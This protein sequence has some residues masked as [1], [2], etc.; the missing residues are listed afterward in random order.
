MNN[1]CWKNKCMSKLM[2]KFPL[3]LEKR[4]QEKNFK[5]RENF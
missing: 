2:S 5:T 4:K 1:I 3:F